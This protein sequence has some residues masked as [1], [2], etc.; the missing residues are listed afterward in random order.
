MRDATVRFGRAFAG[1]LG[2]RE[3]DASDSE[4]VVRATL[5][6]MPPKRKRAGRA[7]D[8]VEVLDPEVVLKEVRRCRALLA[9]AAPVDETTVDLSGMRVVQEMGGDAVALAVERLFVAAAE[10]IARGESFKFD[11][12]S[13]S[14]SNQAYVAALDRIV[15]R[16][17]TSERS[18]ANVSQTRKT[19]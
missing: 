2:R 3:A 13:R 12:P 4:A 18:F 10:S 11:V 1:P 14:A 7:E 15:L 8:E 16:A 5:G 17:N 6:G 19:G 9:A